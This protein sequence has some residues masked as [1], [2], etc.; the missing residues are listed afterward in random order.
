VI[1]LL[2]ENTAQDDASN[3]DAPVATENQLDNEAGDAGIDAGTETDVATDADGST[4]SEGYVPQPELN[5][6]L[7]T[8]V[9]EEEVPRKEVPGGRAYEIIYIARAGDPAA[10]EATAER[11]RA[12]I[13]GSDGAIDHVRTSETR[14]LAYPIKKQNE[15]VY[16]VVNARFQKEM[17]LELDRFMKL[18]ESVLRHMI[19]RDED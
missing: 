15:G 10:V 2:N 4:P 8:P 7:S 17:N 11:V 13:E 19:L 3:D 14:R 5:E 18:E 1:R 12:L 6:A 9:V 16:V